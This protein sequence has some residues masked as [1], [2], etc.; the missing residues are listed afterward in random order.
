MKKRQ[1]TPGSLKLLVA[2]FAGVIVALYLFVPGRG[3][4]VLSDG[5]TWQSQAGSLDRLG[6]DLE[7]AGDTAA[8][9][10]RRARE[11]L[12]DRLAQP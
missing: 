10:L 5:S 8:L 6:G 4:P 3:G 7:R 12:H 9:Y 11:F 2:F 1:K